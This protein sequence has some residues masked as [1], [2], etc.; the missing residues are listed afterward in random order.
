MARPPIPTWFFALVVV[1]KGDRVLLIQ[2]HHKGEPW[3][4]PGGRVEPGENLV[5]AALRETLEESGL[6][7]RLEGIL[8][9]EHT[10]QPSGVR[11]RA[12]F[13]ASPLDDTP[14]KSVPDAESLGAR[15]FTMGELS[16]LRLR[17]PEVRTFFGALLDGAPVA[18]LSILGSERR[19][20]PRTD[21]RGRNPLSATSPRVPSS[22]STASDTAAP[23]APSGTSGP[24]R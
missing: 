17:G 1:R 2:E 13:V 24:R 16:R 6:R 12:I 18:P 4:L 20:E 22:P 14:P 7:V 10:P 3:Y 15:W 8:K 23:G 21:P 11:V 19:L 5:E 9:I